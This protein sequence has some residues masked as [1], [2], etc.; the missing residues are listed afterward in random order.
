MLVSAC[1]RTGFPE[2]CRKP[3]RLPPIFDK[4]SDK[5]ALSVSGKLQLPT[6]RAVHYRI[7]AR[8]RSISFLDLCVFGVMPRG[9]QIHVIE[10][11]SALRPTASGR[12]WQGAPRLSFMFHGFA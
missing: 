9:L 5:D 2:P 11:N 12:G 1:P 7:Q 8:A 6:A 3:C 4:V 10:C